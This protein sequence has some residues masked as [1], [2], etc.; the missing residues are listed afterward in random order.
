MFTL[1]LKGNCYARLDPCGVFRVLVAVGGHA[2]VRRVLGR[3]ARLVAARRVDRVHDGLHE[4]GHQS[5]H[6]RRHE[7]EL[8][9]RLSTHVHSPDGQVARDQ[10]QLRSGPALVVARDQSAPHDLAPHEPNVHYDNDQ[11]ANTTSH[12]SASFNAST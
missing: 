11:E 5:V 10:D 8:Q 3:D 6:L 2:A 4:H 12:H 1:S 9:A 7:R